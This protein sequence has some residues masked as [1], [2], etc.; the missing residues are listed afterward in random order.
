[1][2]RGVT[3][4][5]RSRHR[6][7]RALTALG[8][9]FA[10][11][12]VL[13][14]LAPPPAH[15]ATAD[16]ASYWGR[17]LLVSTSDSGVKANNIN[18][19]P[20]ISAN[21]RQVAFHSE[22]TNLDPAD[23]DSVPDVYAKDTVNGDLVLVSVSEGGQKGNAASDE[24]A[25]SGSG[26]VVAFHSAATN[27]DPGDTDPDRDVY[28]RDLVTGELTLASTTR[29]GVKGDRF[30]W[31]PSLDRSGN[32]VAFASA[33]TNLDPV[34]TN[35][36][37]DVYLKN[38]R[39]GDLRLVSTSTTGATSNGNCGGPDLGA[40]GTRVAFNCDSTNL[41]P[42]DLDSSYDV[43]VKDLSTG[44]LL[45]A[46]TST[47][48]VKLTA[49]SLHPSLSGAGRRVAFDYAGR[50]IYV[51]DLTTGELILASASDDGVT[52]NRESGYPV[53]SGDGRRVAFQSAATNLDPAD[54]DPDSDIYIKDLVTGD[55]ALA[56]IAADGTSANFGGSFFPALSGDGRRVAFDSSVRY[57]DPADADTLLDIYLAQPVLCTAVGTAG[58][59]VL[60][61][62][63]GNDVL[64]GRGGDDTLYGGLGDDVLLGEGGSDVLEGGPGADAMDGGDDAGTDVLTYLDATLGVVVDLRLGL[65]SGSHA[66]GDVFTGFEN[67][68]GG[69]YDDSLFGDD[70]PNVLL[71]GDGND[72]LAGAGGADVLDGGRGDDSLSGGTGADSLIG[73][74]AGSTDVDT[75]T[76]G[77][78]PAAVT[79]NLAGRTAA[80]GSADGDTLSEIDSVVGSPY[81][82]IL[83]G[84]NGINTLV[85]GDGADIL[86]GLSDD[87]IL[88]GG[89]GV[90]TFQGGGGVDTCDAVAGEVTV[91][92]EA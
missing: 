23:T 46:S 87:D 85:G 14:P 65:G 83:A 42:R 68:T 43:Y 36:A 47:S 1:M 39:M 64:C 17:I 89:A 71:G 81:D 12:A 15:A 86:I 44:E 4:S 3:P 53:I 37:E 74:P 52:G 22:A 62:T 20:D 66:E 67:V 79:I 13:V 51:K 9:L 75:I 78:S 76:Y 8:C 30:S 38:V 18:R 31:Y 54:T 6:P 82:D 32:L 41:D 5:H 59:D 80:G 70:G 73:G 19:R 57:L 7:H 10:V 60:T 16:T 26:T 90:D 29:T 77:E 88:R 61:G 33:A 25:I 11:A 28:V 50:D 91:L 45:L 63:T 56:S 2:L 35:V 84:T 21:G 58:D 55:I 34:D 72:V 92:C 24:A 40:A 27:L 69:E 49:I 48:G